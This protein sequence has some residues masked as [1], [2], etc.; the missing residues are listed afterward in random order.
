MEVA[1]FRMPVPRPARGLASS[2]GP[3]AYSGEA[4]LHRPPSADRPRITLVILLGSLAMPVCRTPGQC[5]QLSSTQCLNPLQTLFNYVSAAVLLR[6]NRMTRFGA[7]PVRTDTRF[8]RSGK[9]TRHK[10]IGGRRKLGAPS[11]RVFCEWGGG[12]E[13]ENTASIVATK[14]S[15][16]G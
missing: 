14:K 11:I 6:F 2:T 13:P 3:S 12:H 5:V 15:A 4:L 7:A 8:T 16:A 9:K 1:P 10:K